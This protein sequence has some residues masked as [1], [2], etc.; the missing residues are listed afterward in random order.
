MSSTSLYVTQWHLS[1]AGHIMSNDFGRVVSAVCSR[2]LSHGATTLAE[3]AKGVELPASQLRNALLVLVQHN[4]VKCISKPP[5]KL[6]VNREPSILYEASLDAVFLRRWYPRMLMWVRERYGSDEELVLQE[7][8]AYGRMPMQQLIE[9]AT[10]SYADAKGLAEGSSEREERYNAFFSAATKLRV[11]QLITQSDMLPEDM[12][13]IDRDTVG[14]AAVAA[15]VAAAVRGGGLA[16]PAAEASGG[17]KRKQP[18]AKASPSKATKSEGGRSGSSAAA[19][20][21]RADAAGIAPLLPAEGSGSAASEPL[22]S[23]NVLKFR[24]EFKHTAIKSLVGDKLDSNAE[25]I[26]DKALGLQCS[27]TA[28]IEDGLYYREPFTVDAVLARCPARF[29]E[30]GPQISWQLVLNYLDALCSDP[31]CKMATTLNG[32]YL[33][34]LHELANA[35]KM[36]LAEGAVRRLVGEQGCRLFRLLCRGH[37]LGSCSHKGQQKYELKQ[38]AEMALLPERDARPLLWKLLHHEF[39]RLQEVP[40]SADRNPKTTTYLWHCSL[41]HAYQTLERQMFKALCALSAR[42]TQERKAAGEERGE[43]GQPSGVL[44]RPGATEL[45]MSDEQRLAAQRARARLETLD[46]AIMKLFDTA[47]T[48]RYM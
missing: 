16:G 11:D 34:E 46:G 23:A 25:G 5:G 47:L 38:L 2:L 13:K 3:L 21:S 6:Q 41:P 1:M 32:K 26:V 14:D 19:S 4:I 20:S 29:S 30:D 42:L 35:V 44:R 48:L 36:I 9:S 22:V 15:A 12:A 27:A 37:A 31:L 8:L 7:L 33:I 17:R 43:S 18:A 28:Y 45:D 40:R 10:Q 24:W 39:V